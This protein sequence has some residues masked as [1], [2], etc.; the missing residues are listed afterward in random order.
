MLMGDITTITMDPKELRAKA[1]LVERRKEE[2]VRLCL[3]RPVQAR[4]GSTLFGDVRLIHNALPEIDFDDIDAST[5]F[6]GH[7]F[8]A[9]IMIGAMTGGAQISKKIN[10]NL[11]EAA[12]ELG[13][14]MSVG[15]Q[16]AGLL[17][18]SLADTY[19]VARQAGPHIF[20]GSNIGG[21]Q[22][23]HGLGLGEAKKLINMLDAD[24]LYVH[25]NPLQELVQPE[26][27]PEY[28][29]VL[30]KIK[31]LI[32]GLDKPVVVKEVG[33]GISDQ[34]ARRLEAVGASAIEVAGSG[35]TSWPGVES[36]RAK[37]AGD[38]LRFAAGNM[39]WDWGIP[40]AAALYGVRR[41][42]KIPV[43]ASGGLRTGLDV[44][45]AMAMGADLCATAWPLL[46]PAT[47]SS[48]KVREYL[49]NVIF[50]L[51]S[52]MFVTG[53]R[54]VAELRKSRY[55]VTGELKDWCALFD[56]A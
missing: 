38:T 49:E 40:T 34:V 13:I 45:K 7:R 53:C 18:K 39:L 9:P 37:E 30:A 52:V 35:G 27:E 54:N 51:K 16:R 48:A 2:G 8:S 29:G 6:L 32:A 26:G 46:R 22:L 14:G 43:V 19:S 42:V 25:L 20:L 5:K 4:K 44:A 24:A 50:V 23:S 10:R 55:I 12:E 11:A 15:S 3:D 47:V 31:D 41:S 21:A 33:S 28:N 36:Y 1:V 17:T 56:K